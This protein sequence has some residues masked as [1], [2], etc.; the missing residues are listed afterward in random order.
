M[1]KNYDLIVIG[2]GPAGE[3]GAAQ[4]AYFG[5]H[6]ALIEQADDLGG[7]AANTGTLPSKTLRETALHLTGFRHRDLSGIDVQLR[8]EV[9]AQ[10]F[11]RRARL[12]AETERQRIGANLERHDVTLIRGRASFV[13]PDS[14]ELRRA[15]GTTEEVSADVIL[16]A[17]GSSPYRPPYLPFDDSRVYD[18]DTILDIAQMPEAMVVVGGGVIGSEYACMFAALDVDVKLVEARDRLL[19]F[20]D[21]EISDILAQSMRDLG[22]ELIL[23]DSIEKVTA[24]GQLDVYLA[25]GRRIETDAILAATGRTGNSAGLGLEAVGIDPADGVVRLSLLHY[26]HPG[27]VAKVLRELD[28][29]M[30]R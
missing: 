30:S 23:E 10:E 20:M 4:A 8:Q 24:D 22:V 26:N 29:A 11:L 19:G 18:S 15:D 1:A 12:V 6:V 14:L 9:G 13:A 17:T 21:R 25:S 5:K 3:K 7:A 2:S 28:A 16:I 27:D